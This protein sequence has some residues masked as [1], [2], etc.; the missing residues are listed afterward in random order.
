M[1][2]EYYVGRKHERE[3]IKK[4]LVQLINEKKTKMEIKQFIEKL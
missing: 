1:N 2:W 3:N 4:D